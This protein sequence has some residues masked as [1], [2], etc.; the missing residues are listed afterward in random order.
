MAHDVAS[1]VTKYR[2]NLGCGVLDVLSD[3]L[4]KTHE[5]RT[6]SVEPPG[7]DDVVR[8]APMVNVIEVSN[9]VTYGSPE[10]GEYATI[11]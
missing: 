8:S 1:D 10:L 2:G 6:R 3:V 5:V 9:T 11:I 4:R 7:G